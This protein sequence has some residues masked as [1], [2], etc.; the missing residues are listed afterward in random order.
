MRGCAERSSGRPSPDL[1][2][3]GQVSRIMIGTRNVMHIKGGLAGEEVPLHVLQ[4]R[5]RLWIHFHPHTPLSR[6]SGGG[7]R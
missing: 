6:I 2:I 5:L 1:Y 4:E 3:V 7:F